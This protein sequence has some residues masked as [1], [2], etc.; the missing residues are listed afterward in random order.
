MAR[1]LINIEGL[2]KKDALKNLKKNSMIFDL[3]KLFKII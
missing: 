1:D 3:E 2:R